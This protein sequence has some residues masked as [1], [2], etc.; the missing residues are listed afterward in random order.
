MGKL[1][2]LDVLVL[3]GGLGTR[4]RGVLGDTPKVLAPI[5]GRPFL[6][7]LLDR[8]AAQG[9]GRA[10]LALGHLADKVIAHL[11]THQ[12]PLP[13]VTV[14]EPE[15][16]GTAGA[17]RHA[18]A[19]T[20]GDAVMVM[21]G[22]TW[23]DVDLAAFEADWRRAGTPAGLL[24]VRVADVSRFGSVEIG[25]DGTLARFTE[26]DPEHTGAGLINAGIYLFGRTLLDELAAYPGP[27]LERD[28]LARLPA[29][30]VAVSVAEQAAFVDIG[31][32]ES[33]AGAGT[34]MPTPQEKTA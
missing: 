5:N 21:N 12:A 30:S 23:V 8:L 26:K 4:I 2:G 31:T 7:H 20:R 3:A 14:V 10:V 11:R 19:S 1:S 27:S 25:V 32:P 13:V 18:N 9:A 33:L 22:D 6:D 15:P 17:L 28:V 24:S 16:L 34:V 29:G